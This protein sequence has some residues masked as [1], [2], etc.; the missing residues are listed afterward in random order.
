MTESEDNGAATLGNT[1]RFLVRL[2]ETWPEDTPMIM[3]KD[4]EG[5]AYSPLA[6]IQSNGLYEAYTTYSG[7]YIVTECDE[8]PPSGVPAICLW[9]TY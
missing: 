1:V 2:L 9:P 4:G 6:D 3:A 5:N 8:D 7:D